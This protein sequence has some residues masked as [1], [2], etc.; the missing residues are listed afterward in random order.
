MQENDCIL[1]NSTQ[2]HYGFERKMQECEFICILFHP[3]LLRC[4]KI[5]YERYVEPIIRNSSIEYL[6]FSAASDQG[7][8]FSGHLKEILALRKKHPAAYELDVM[9]HFYAIWKELYL[10][11]R[12]HLFSK[13]ENTASD[14]S[15]QKKMV[16]F[17]YQRFTE[18]LSLDE[19]AAAGSISRSK[20]CIIFKRYLNQSPIDFLN[21]YRLEVACN[22]LKST[23]YSITRIAT[24]CGFNHLSYFS[25]MFERKY[26]CTPSNYRRE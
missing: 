26:G 23:D 5:L 3:D 11:C 15:L 25:K 21:S 20:C 12:E 7:L 9:E 14:I 4:N 19:I 16:S 18:A 6:Y 2:M 24:A 22:L 17:I 1:V 10:H 13:E 8:L